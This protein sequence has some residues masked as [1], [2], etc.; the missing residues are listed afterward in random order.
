LWCSILIHWSIRSFSAALNDGKE[1]I[2]VLIRHKADVN[3]VD[4]KNTSAL[5]LAVMS[6]NA[7]SVQVL[8]DGKVDITVKNKVWKNNCFGIEFM[9]AKCNV[10]ALSV[11]V[12]GCLLCRK[13]ALTSDDLNDSISFELTLDYWSLVTVVC[14]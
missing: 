1:L 4:N 5:M 13:L 8:L 10:N 11:S 7:G 3:A 2:Q 14:C 12:N 6:G 9:L